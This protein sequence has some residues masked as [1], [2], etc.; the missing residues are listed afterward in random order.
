MAVNIF[1]WRQV[2]G[3]INVSGQSLHGMSFVSLAGRCGQE[4]FQTDIFLPKS[5]VACEILSDI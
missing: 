3:V 2:F 4:N 5:I 1:P